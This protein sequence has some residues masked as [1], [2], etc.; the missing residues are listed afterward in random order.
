[1]I[2]VRISILWFLDFQ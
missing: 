1:M 2:Y